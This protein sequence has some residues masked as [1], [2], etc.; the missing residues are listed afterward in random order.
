MNRRKFLSLGAATAA[1]P[2]LPALS[3]SSAVAPV[4]FNG[5][6]YG[7]AVFHARTRASL[8]AAELASRLRVSTPIAQGMIAKMR[9]DGF[10]RLGANGAVQAI[11]R[12]Q[13]SSQ[14]L[15]ASSEVKNTLKNVFDKCDDNKHNNKIAMADTDSA[16]STD[17]ER[18]ERQ[19]EH[20]TQPNH[21]TQDI[22]Q[23]TQ[24]KH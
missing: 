21:D 14:G 20:E 24:N 19:S 23:E 1:T 10:V 2:L 6:Q 4:S 16:Q 11:T 3:F 17:L 7:L 22:V 8:S 15:T 5:Y 9:A 18:E 13:N 12:F